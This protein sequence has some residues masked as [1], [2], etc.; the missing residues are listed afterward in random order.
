M[1]SLWAT[2]TLLSSQGLT[3]A[4][5]ASLNQAVKGLAIVNK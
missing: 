3:S 1:A 5:V 4:Q 2:E